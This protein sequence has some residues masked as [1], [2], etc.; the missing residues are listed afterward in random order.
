VIN[1]IAE[2]R[3]LINDLK[4]MRCSA[5]LLTGN[6]PVVELVPTQTLSGI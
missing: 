5:V 4:I 3:T 1:I 2:A 6:A